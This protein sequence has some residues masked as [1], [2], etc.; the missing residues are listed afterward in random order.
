MKTK[1]IPPLLA[2]ACL[3]AL[4]GCTSYRLGSMLPPNLSSVYVKTFVNETGEPQLEFQTTSATV[5]EFQQDGTL[6]V[7]E[8]DTADAVLD[9]KLTG[10]KVTP[11]RYS[12]TSLTTGREY[13]LLLTAEAVLKDVKSGKVIATVTAA[14]GETTFFVTA[15]LK[16]DERTAVPAAAQDLAHHIVRNLV[17]YW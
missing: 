3:L 11:V 14:Q 7:A 13:R 5:R 4:P 10:Y 2:L 8:Q 6:R 12:K 1:R 16:S 17:E 9:T 15:D